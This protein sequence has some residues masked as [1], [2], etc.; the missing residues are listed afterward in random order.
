VISGEIGRKRHF[1]CLDDLGEGLWPLAEVPGVD[2]RG[3]AGAWK[4]RNVAQG[5]QLGTASVGGDAKRHTEAARM[6]FGF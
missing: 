3:H 2:P 6:P 4:S 1:D 5:A